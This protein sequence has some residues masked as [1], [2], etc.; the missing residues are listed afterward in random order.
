MACDRLGRCG[1]GRCSC[2]TRLPDLEALYI[3]TL[4][5]VVALIVVGINPSSSGSHVSPRFTRH[6]RT[7]QLSPY[8]TC[9]PLGPLLLFQAADS[10]SDMA[11]NIEGTSPVRMDRPELTITEASI[12]DVPVEL[13]GSPATAA[14]AVAVAPSAPH[15]E[16]LTPQERE[17]RSPSIAPSSSAHMLPCHLSPTDPPQRRQQLISERKGDSAVLVDIPQTPGPEELS[18]SASADGDDVFQP[19]NTINA[20]R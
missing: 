10:P 12:N 3:Y 8:Y 19:D 9:D 14:T 18:K 15:P 4:A 20:A 13:E 7:A 6:S 1:N 17:V 2:I 16:E 5:V 11:N